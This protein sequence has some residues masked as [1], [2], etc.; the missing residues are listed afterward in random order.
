MEPVKRVLGHAPPPL[1][2]E[3]SERAAAAVEV[4][5][6]WGGDLLRVVHL[7]PPRSFYV[8]DG[9]CDLAIDGEA[10]GGRRFPAVLAGP[11]GVSVVAP[12]GATGTIV[13]ASGARASVGR[14]VEEGLGEAL[15]GAVSGTRIPLVAGAR[16]M[17]ALPGPVGGAAYRTAGG[18]ARPPGG[19]PVVLEIALV[20]PGRVVGRG[21]W[22]R[23]SGRLV[24]STALAAG[25]ALACL[26]LTAPRVL[27]PD[28]Q[29]AEAE[30]EEAFVRAGVE[31][32]AVVTAREIAEFPEPVEDPEP[33][34]ANVGFISILGPPDNTFD[35]EAGCR[36]TPGD[37]FGVDP[38][39]G[40]CPSPYGASFDVITPF[41]LRFSAVPE[42]PDLL[43]RDRP[44]PYWTAVAGSWWWGA[45]SA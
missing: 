41:G 33:L 6:L 31:A 17:L 34:P 36:N 14:A 32:Y 30:A 44:D 29:E 2:V 3:E 22:L 37:P 28:E 43:W 27:F 18:E 8:G 35:G 25:M 23:G 7:D 42:L 40:P 12:R 38:Y 16:V 39:T 5:V 45:A 24:A 11:G 15:A 21:G 20:R 1:S 26:A 10:L 4:R 9:A 19:A 13:A